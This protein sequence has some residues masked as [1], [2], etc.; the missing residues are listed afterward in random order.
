[1][2]TPP[3][4]KNQL[5]IS[6]SLILGTTLFTPAYAQD[7][8]SADKELEV[9]QVQGIRGS[10]IKAMDIKRS[11]DGVVEAISAED[12]GKFP[13]TNLA[14]SLQRITG[15]SIDRSD[16]E[17]SRVTIR[18][19]GSDNNLV[20]LN[21]RQM[22]TPTRSFDFADLASEGVSA[23]EV[24]KTGRA[25]IATGGLGGT[26]NI[27]TPRPLANPGEQ[28]SLGVKA[29]HD[30]SNQKG[31]AWTPELSGL[32]SNTF[33]DDRLGISLTGSY[34]KR[35]SGNSN[36][37]VGSGWRAFVSGEDEGGW[38][39]LP[40]EDPDGSYLNK[41]AEGV[42]YAVPQNLV[43]QFNEA[44]RTRKNGQLTLEYQAT[45]KLKAR[46]DYTYSE[47]RIQ[48]ELTDMS[49]WFS[50]D[51]RNATMVW[52][53]PNSENVAY[54]IQYQDTDNYSAD[55]ERGSGIGINSGRGYSATKNTNNSLGLN[56]EYQV[57]DNLNLTLDYHDASAKHEPNSPYGSWGSLAMISENRIRSTVDFSQVLPVL[58]IGY[59]EGVEGFE[60]E[61]MIGAGS[62]FGNNYERSEI[63]QAQ[64]DGTWVFD[65][66]VI[67]SID[68]GL[69]QT[70][71]KNNSRYAS[72]TRGTWSGVGEP[73]DWED[74]WFTQTD[75]PAMFD[76]L[77]GH[78]DPDMEPY[79]IDWDFDTIAQFTA[80]NF[81]TG[82]EVEWPC[83][84]VFCG[85]TNYSTNRITEEKMQA[86]YVQVNWQFDIGN[87]PANLTTGVRYE[88]TETQASALV[89]NY[90]G[91]SWSSTN[92][93]VLQPTGDSV[94]TDESGDYN[95]VLPSID[96]RIELTEDLVARASYS[97]TIS[98]PSYTDMQGGKTL[99]GQITAIQGNGSRGDPGLLPL[100]SDNYDLSLEWYY[101]EASYAAVGWFNKDVDNFIG[102]RTVMETAFD[103]RNPAQGPRADAAR[104]AGAQGNDEIRQY[105]LENYL[106]SDPNVYLNDNGD[107]VIDATAEDELANFEITIP[108][109][110][111]EASVHGW[112]LTVQHMFWDTGFGVN[113]NGTIVDG[114]LYYDN[115]SLEP[116]F[117]LYGLSDSANFIAFYEDDRYSIRVAYNWRDEFLAYIG[118]GSGDNPVY[119]EAYGQWD[120][121]MSYNVTENLTVFAEGINLT[122]EY[123]RQHGRHEQMLINLRQTAPRYNVGVRYQF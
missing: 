102:R 2:R 59:P 63:E 4:F 79:Y 81:Y 76:N 48:R 51:Y 13:D 105:I 115:A 66:G 45:D 60:P 58:S 100:E 5:A 35:D 107:V 11:S 1:M 121:N 32:Y 21:G 42:T 68:F 114:D 99:G 96:F 94:F 82:N 112:E 53:D 19:F 62:N 91:I 72:A 44:S 101:D 22:P 17:G 15:V 83:G 69:S 23:V 67:E 103:L 37:T 77:P 28:A 12:I 65:S 49:T 16:G 55:A 18:G 84:Q 90:D 97:K 29:V 9:I 75:L 40:A 78:A 117:A 46:V 50:F 73:D 71:V 88:K 57:N 95:N 116:Q 30:R 111:R 120:I 24:Y 52:S 122:N 27:I 36:A 123:Q 14:E 80:E 20:L 61:D 108:Y 33:L 54:P 38:G 39:A 86:A 10:M 119:T 92:E 26:I 34:Q 41:P 7:S 47:N 43:Y 113:V 110:Q 109:N 31:D 70:E 85:G 106:D 89:P 3:F 64:I 87:M 25:S 6:V 8:T 56:L 98:R 93:L 74:S 118:D 104:A